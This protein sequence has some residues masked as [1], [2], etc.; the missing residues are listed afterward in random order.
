MNSSRVFRTRLDLIA[1]QR[2]R[3][4]LPAQAGIY[5]TC[6]ANLGA[7][8]APPPDGRLSREAVAAFWP[9]VFLVRNLR[10]VIVVDIRVDEFLRPQLISLLKVQSTGVA[11]RPLR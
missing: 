10:R 7:S 8:L 3:P 5:S 1:A 4:L 6:I 11:E 2:Q 9:G